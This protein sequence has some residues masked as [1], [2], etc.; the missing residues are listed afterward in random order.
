M[1]GPVPF[2]KRQ[3]GTSFSLGSVHP[4]TI[5]SSRT[6][7]QQPDKNLTVLIKRIA[8]IQHLSIGKQLTVDHC[9]SSIPDC[10]DLRVVG[11]ENKG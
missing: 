2:V 11:H 1:D 9:Q 3:N 7:V 4:V 5:Y 8:Q 6:P 10:T